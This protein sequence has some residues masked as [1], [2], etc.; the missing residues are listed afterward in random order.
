MKTIKVR[1]SWEDNYCAASDAVLG[2]VATHKTFG[3]IKKAYA[4]ALKFH[5]EAM[6][7]DGDDLPE[8]LKGEYSLEFEP[9]T[10]ALLQNGFMKKKWKKK[11]FEI[12]AEYRVNP[13]DISLSGDLF[14]ADKRNVEHVDK[15]IQEIKEGNFIRIETKEELTNFLASL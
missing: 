13:F 1:I 6:R 10:Q 3:G 12:P 15:S 4:S 5:L 9:S 14:W 11:F 2:C 8:L 7:L